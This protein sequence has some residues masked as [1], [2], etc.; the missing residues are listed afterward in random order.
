M[1]D[2]NVDL[3]GEATERIHSVA[4]LHAQMKLPAIRL[5]RFAWALQVPPALLLQTASWDTS[6]P[7]SLAVGDDLP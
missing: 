2:R 6:C 4:Q 7:E 3:K 1:L 5:K